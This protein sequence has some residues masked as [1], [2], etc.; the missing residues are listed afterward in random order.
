MSNVTIAECVFEVKDESGNK[1]KLAILIMQPIQKMDWQCNVEIHNDG[2]KKV[3][4]IMGVDSYQSLKLAVDFT[5]IEI[6]SLFNEYGNR[7]STFGDQS[8]R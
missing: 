5:E 1:S 7:I 8:Y 2:E 4:E 3:H 6:K